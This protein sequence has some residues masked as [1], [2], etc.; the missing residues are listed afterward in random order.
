MS[1]QSK[2]CNAMQKESVAALNAIAQKYGFTVRE[3]GGTIGSVDVTLKFKFTVADK[4]ALSEAER[5]KFNLYCGMFNML[6]SD[7][8]AEFSIKG[9]PHTLIGFNARR[10][11]FPVIARDM[12]SGKTILYTDLVLDRVRALRAKAAA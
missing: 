5:E 3:N 12:N 6:P 9:V 11:K 7:Y 1:I 8:R 2:T 4:A 10:P